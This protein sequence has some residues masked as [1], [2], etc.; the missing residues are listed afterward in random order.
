MTV[1]YCVV[2]GW[3]FGSFALVGWMVGRGLWCERQRRRRLVFAD[4]R[5]CEDARRLGVVKGR[6]AYAAGLPMPPV[7]LLPP[8]LDPRDGM[9][10]LCR[11]LA[12]RTRCAYATGLYAGWYEAC[13][14]QLAADLNSLP[15]VA[16]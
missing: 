16:A 13:E 14:R 6:A 10:R 11:V 2:G 5:E 12:A 15:T 8:R 3:V 9:D 4:R 7:P 1:A